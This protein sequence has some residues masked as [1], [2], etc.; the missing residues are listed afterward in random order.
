MATNKPFQSS[1]A[2]LAPRLGRLGWR[3]LIPLHPNRKYPSIMQW[4]RFNNG[5]SQADIEL[6]AR[7]P[8]ALLAGSG[9]GM[10]AGNGVTAVDIDIL[11]P[12][13]AT[14]ATDIAFDV[15]G[16]TPLIRTGHAPK[17]MLFY[18]DDDT[19]RKRVNPAGLAL[20]VFPGG[21]PASGQVVLFGQH[22]DG[23]PYAYSGYTPLDLSPDHLP[24]I[25]AEHID[26]LVEQLAGD[27]LVTEHGSVKARRTSARRTSAVPNSGGLPLQE[28][29]QAAAERRL[30]DWL[31]NI[32]PGGR[33]H[34]ATA[35]VMFVV[36]C[37]LEHAQETYEL[38]RLARAFDAVKPGC[39]SEFRGIVG[40]ARKN[41]APPMP[42]TEL[43]RKL[44]LEGGVL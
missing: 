21:R 36:G 13:A 33:H 41:C 1:F 6:L 5:Q 26:L 43:D 22:P 39:G 31:K 40:W 37:G 25:T 2:S 7:S 16:V 35:A 20:E 19:E 3:G 29:A 38:G 28:A 32:E 34:A 17:V 9:V 18:A 42:A 24:G 10:C 15:L 30:T 11:V 23:Y 12:Q 8:Q 14:R 4:E 44:G 27:P